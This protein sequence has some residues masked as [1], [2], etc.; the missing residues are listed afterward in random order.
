MK[1]FEFYP[2]MVNRLRTFPKSIPIMKIIRA[3]NEFIFKEN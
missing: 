1:A 3:L 2:K